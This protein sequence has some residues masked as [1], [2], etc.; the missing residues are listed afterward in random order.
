MEETFKIDELLGVGFSDEIKYFERFFKSI[1]FKR[2]EGTVYGLLTLSPIA[3]SSEEIEA[4]LQLSQAAISQSLKTLNNYGAIEINDCRERGRRLHSATEDCLSI[5]ANVFCKRE[6]D[7]IHQYKLMCKRA[8]KRA[9]SNGENSESLR[10]KRLRSIISTCDMG[11]VVINFILSVRDLQ[12][13]ERLNK[14]TDRLSMV[15]HGVI[16]G[17]TP[18]QE[19]VGQIKH[20]LTNKLRGRL[21]KIAGEYFEQ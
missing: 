6:N 10:V 17:M 9:L 15:L 1:G 3:L 4:Y 8:L 14:V 21:E 7:I 2:T 13:H 12:V 5:V 11:E 19:V 16:G 20:S 18:P